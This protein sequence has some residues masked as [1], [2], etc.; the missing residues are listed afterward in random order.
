MDN[1]RAPQKKR[2]S[3]LHSPGIGLN[4]CVLPASSTTQYPY[5]NRLNSKISLPSRLLRYK[6]QLL[7]RRSTSINKYNYLLLNKTRP[8]DHIKSQRINPLRLISMT[9]G[10]PFILPTICRNASHLQPHQT[11]KR[12]A[13]HFLMIRSIA[14]ALTT[15]VLQLTS[16][17]GHSPINH[18]RCFHAHNHSSALF[19]V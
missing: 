7:S 1:S 5:D 8:P 10:M 3:P 12:G 17:S 19:T 6:Q 11:F 15:P 14:S 9:I 4:R 18:Y 13:G 2:P 16:D